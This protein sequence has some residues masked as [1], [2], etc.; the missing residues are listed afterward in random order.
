MV[1]LGRSSLLDINQ[2]HMEVEIK[3]PHIF[4]YKQLSFSGFS[5]GFHICVLGLVNR[6]LCLVK[7]EG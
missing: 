3:V 1:L 2:E 6:L 5:L 7:L 4:C